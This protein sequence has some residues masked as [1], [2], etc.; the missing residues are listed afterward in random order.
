[1]IHVIAAIQVKP[2]NVQKFIDIFKTNVPHVLAEKGCIDYVPTIDMD[3]GLPPQ[4]RD[5]GTVTIIERWD[6]LDDLHAHLKTPHMLA[7]REKVKDI[8]Q[9]MSLKVLQEV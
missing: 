2:G 9:G 4:Q 6:S 8:V 7:Y 1:M 5:A 3:A